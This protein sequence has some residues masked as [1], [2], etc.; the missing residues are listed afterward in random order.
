[1]MNEYALV[2]G[3]NLR[4]L[5]K[6]CNEYSGLNDLIKHMLLKAYQKK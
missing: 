2:F 4:Q 6:G 5:V 3:Q 1:M